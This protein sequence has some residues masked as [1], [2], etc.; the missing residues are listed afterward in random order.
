MGFSLQDWADITPPVKSVGSDTPAGIWS[1]VTA[2]PD[3]Q[4]DGSA[5]ILNVL[6]GILRVGATA[7]YINLNPATPKI[8]LF[9][10]AARKLAIGQLN[11]LYDYVASTYGFVTGE[12]AVSKIWLA[13]EQ[14]N[15][16]R[17]MNNTVQLA[18][19]DTSGNILIGQIGVG[20]S[21]VYITSGAV[22]LRNNV[23]ENI[24]L[25]TDG[26]G[27]LAGNGKLNWDASG[28]ITMTGSIVAGQLHIPDQ[29][30]T[31]NSLH[32]NTVGDMWFG[33]TETNFNNDNNNA[34]AYI[35]KTGI[36]KFQNITT[37]GTVNIGH[38]SSD[39]FIINFDNTD[40]DTE[41][42][43]GR[44]TGGTASFTWNGALVQCSKSFLPTEL[45]INNISASEPV[46]PF[47]KQI[48][49]DVS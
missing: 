16:I 1:F 20:Q 11:G 40:I 8:E 7:N 42:R 43:F 35:L 49:L 2:G 38:T 41:L 9:E 27:W 12:K 26:S 39:F 47:A 3:V 46:T 32:V 45:G 34:A 6:P 28:N 25:A 18:Q 30:V 33:C 22:Y 15:G 17:I 14:T 36:A 31:A 10:G 23:T 44:T 37:G 24:K 21:N 29:D 4:D 19:W 13:V 5:Q 48:W